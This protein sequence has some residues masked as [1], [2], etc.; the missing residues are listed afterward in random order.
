M[1]IDGF[2]LEIFSYKKRRYEETYS[3]L[4]RTDHLVISFLM[5][6]AICFTTGQTKNLK[7][8]KKMYTKWHSNHALGVIKCN[9]DSR[10]NV[11]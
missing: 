3:S 9:L 2:F 11:Y 5:Y 8:T 7:E 1:E 10:K 4:L 6:L